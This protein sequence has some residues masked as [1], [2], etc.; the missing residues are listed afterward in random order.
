MRIAVTT[1][2]NIICGHFG[3]AKNFSVFTVEDGKIVSREELDTQ[4]NHCATMPAF[5]KENNIDAV[6]TSGMGQ[7]A[8]DGLAAV[9]I[10]SY[11][12]AMGDPVK[13]VEKLIE[14]ELKNVGANCSGHEH[15]SCHH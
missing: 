13:A 12:G 3:H 11:S 2:N 1:E 5:I 15:G 6:I 10:K 14:G 8:V 4:G 9:G 7:G